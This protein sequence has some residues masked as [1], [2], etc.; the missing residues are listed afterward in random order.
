MK[1]DRM[2]VSGLHLQFNCDETK[3]N[4]TNKSILAIKIH[5]PLT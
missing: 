1:V 4:S 5:L 2:A 3:K